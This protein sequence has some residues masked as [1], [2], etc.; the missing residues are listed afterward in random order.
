MQQIKATRMELLKLKNQLKTAEK[1]YNLLKEKRDGLMKKFMEI[2]KE[3]QRKKEEMEKFLQHTFQDFI[4]STSSMLP[5]E[6]NQIFYPKAFQIDLKIEKENVM[7]ILIPKFKKEIR[8]D[9][10]I[11]SQF[12]SPLQVEEILKRYLQALR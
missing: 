4:L 11:Y 3:A 9:F 2:I 7:S 10:K 6:I 1:G 5:E 8:G 12:T